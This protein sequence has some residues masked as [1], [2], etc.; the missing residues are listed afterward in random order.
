MIWVA[1][2]VDYAWEELTNVQSINR[3]EEATTR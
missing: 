2:T 3:K 1:Q